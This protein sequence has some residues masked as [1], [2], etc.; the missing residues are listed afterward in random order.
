MQF[1]KVKNNRIIIIIDKYISI[2]VIMDRNYIY[3]L[4]ILDITIERFSLYNRLHSP[5]T[6]D[7]IRII[8]HRMGIEYQS[9]IIDLA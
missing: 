7:Y 1:L 5:Y 2:Q 8:Q 6:F 4:E 9:L 3:L